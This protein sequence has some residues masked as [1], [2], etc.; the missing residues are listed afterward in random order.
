MTYQDV[1]SAPTCERRFFLNKLINENE[2]KQEEAETRINNMN[3][4]GAK[5]TR[6]TKMGG[7]QLKSKMKSGEIA[8]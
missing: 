7:E 3:S 6:T 8:N 1:L 2:K 4:K 5:G